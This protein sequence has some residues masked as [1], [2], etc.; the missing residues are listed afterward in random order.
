MW[1][2]VALR[3]TTVGH[4]IDKNVNNN[5]TIILH[6]ITLDIEPNSKVGVLGKNGCG[7]S[8]LLQIIADTI[9]GSVVLDGSVFRTNN[10]K[11]AYYQQHQQDMLPYELSPLQ[12]LVKYCQDNC[13]ENYNEQSLRAHLGSFGLSGDLALR[14]IG[15][16]SGGQKARV[17]LAQLTLNSPHLLL[18]DEP[19]NNLDMDSVSALSKALG[20]YNGAYVVASH[21]MHFVESTCSTAIYRVQ[22]NKVLNNLL[23]NSSSKT[24]VSNKAGVKNG[25]NNDNLLSEIPFSSLVRLEKGVQDYITLVRDSI[26]KQSATIS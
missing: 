5:S 21:D 24:K 7:K 10:V 1:G 11:I 9:G 4:A 2:P 18:L 22:P 25:K 12:Y 16:L 14:L 15:I 19:T 20:N 13:L 23:S 3:S 6:R 17:V 26:A 8:T